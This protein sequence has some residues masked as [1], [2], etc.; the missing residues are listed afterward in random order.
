MTGLV[1]R[2]D[3]HPL[4]QDG[5]DYHDETADADCMMVVQSEVNSVGYEGRSFRTP[6]IVDQRF[7]RSYGDPQH[8]CGDVEL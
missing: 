1:C 2:A 5:V 6:R 4:L 3:A 7:R 8:A